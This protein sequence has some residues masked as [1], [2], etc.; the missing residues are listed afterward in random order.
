MIHPKVNFKK[1]GN[2]NT[3]MRHVDHVLYTNCTRKI[4]MNLSRDAGNESHP[5]FCHFGHL[6]PHRRWSTELIPRPNGM[7]YT[8]AIPFVGVVICKRGPPT[9]D[10]TD[11]R[12]SL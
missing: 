11:K 6:R 2:Y 9:D 8:K 10:N 7:P 12:L 4:K 1:R 5:A 3:S